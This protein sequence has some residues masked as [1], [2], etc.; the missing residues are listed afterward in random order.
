MSASFQL[1]AIE[2]LVTQIFQGKRCIIGAPGRLSF[3][4]GILHLA[5][6]DRVVAFFY[7]VHQ[8]ALN[9]CR[10]ILENRRPQTALVKRLAAD[11]IALSL[12]G[13]EESKRLPLLIL[14]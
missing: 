8:F 5:H 1:S 3:D 10:C 14:S 7:G 12:Q 6:E 2:N 13:L 4:P 9:E 11:G